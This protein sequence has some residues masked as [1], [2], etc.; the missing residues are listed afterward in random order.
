MSK[1]HICQEIWCGVTVWV[2]YKQ[3]SKESLK[4]VFGQY[5]LYVQ[6]V[7]LRGVKYLFYLFD[8]IFIIFIIFISI[9][10]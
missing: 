1:L 2:L 8:V 7:L 6:N 5:S 3:S 9:S 10:C 4:H